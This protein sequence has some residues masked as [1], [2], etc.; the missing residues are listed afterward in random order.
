MAITKKKHAPSQDSVKVY[1]R[2]LYSHVLANPV[3]YTLPIFGSIRGK[4]V[5]GRYMKSL[6]VLKQNIKNATNLSI[7]T[8]KHL[9]GR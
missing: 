8:K 9:T 1:E 3:T 7:A 4:A 6:Y 5:W 2:A